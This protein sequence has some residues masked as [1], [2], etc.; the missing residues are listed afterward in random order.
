MKCTRERLDEVDRG[1]PARNGR[2][3]ERGSIKKLRD[4]GALRAGRRDPLT[5]AIPVRILPC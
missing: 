3:S 4:C 5:P 1:R 2:E